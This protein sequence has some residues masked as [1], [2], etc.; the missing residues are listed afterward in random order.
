MSTD[1]RLARAL[2][3]TAIH[4]LG[5]FIASLDHSSDSHKY[6]IT[7]EAPKKDRTRTSQRDFFAGHKSF[8]TDQ[9]AKL[10]AQI[11][12]REWLGDFQ[13]N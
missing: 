13:E 4:E 6:M 9:K 3:N 10:V 1:R 2:A 11:R 12:K 8:T 7:G 5:H